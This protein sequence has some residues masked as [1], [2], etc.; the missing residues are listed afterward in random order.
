VLPGNNFHVFDYPLFWQAV[1]LDAAARVQAWKRTG[2]AA[3]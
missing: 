1:R 3:R 2:K